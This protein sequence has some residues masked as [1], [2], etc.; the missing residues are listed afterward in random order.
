M[1]KLC[2]SFFCVYNVIHALGAACSCDAAAHDKHRIFVRTVPANMYSEWRHE[3]DRKI[4]S[5]TLG[6]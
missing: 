2:R 6:E 5:R 1:K 4:L 3:Y